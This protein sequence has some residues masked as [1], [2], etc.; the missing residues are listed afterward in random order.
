M[1]YQGNGEADTHMQINKCCDLAYALSTLYSK[2][3]II[4]E[5]KDHYY[6]LTL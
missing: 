4:K 6:Y 2:G 3:L 5:K 1:L